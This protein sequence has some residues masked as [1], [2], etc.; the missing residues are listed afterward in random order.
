MKQNDPIRKENRKALKPFLVILAVC[1][2]VGILAGVLMA[3]LEDYGLTENFSERL[4]E[5]F[6]AWSS[7]LMLAVFLIAFVL[8]LL[9]YRKAKALSAV[10]DGEDEA[11]YQRIDALL[12]RTLLAASSAQILVMLLFGAC[13]TLSDFFSYG[14]ALCHT[15]ILLVSFGCNA[16]F[17]QKAVDLVRRLNPEKQ[18]SV[19]D[20]HF[21]K[22]WYDSCDEAERQQIGEASRFAFQTANGIVCPLLWVAAALLSL[23]FHTGP[24]AVILVSVLWLAL[25]L[26]YQLKA[27]QLSRAARQ[28]AGGTE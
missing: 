26:S 11:Q 20:A 1:F 28:D 17:Q 18:G 12:C 15:G 21:Q 8:A 9:P 23:C 16:L 10:W 3:A 5:A 4:T 27:M 25:T 22:K 14:R 7:V 19:Y 2:V 13:L 24:L 6:V